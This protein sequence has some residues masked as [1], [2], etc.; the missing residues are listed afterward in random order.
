[1]LLGCG[2][3]RQLQLPFDPW[4]GNFHMLQ[5]QPLKK[6]KSWGRAREPSWEESQGCLPL[7]GTDSDVLGFHKRVCASLERD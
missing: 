4:P 1:M 5:V 7:L 3:A 2:L 6:K